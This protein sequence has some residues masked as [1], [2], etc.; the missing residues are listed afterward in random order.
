[1]NILNFKS[2]EIADKNILEP[3]FI[4]YGA[5]SCQ[6]SF[7]SSICR[8]AKYNDDYC[9]Y[10]DY[11][12]VLR[13]GISDENEFKFLFPLG[14][15]DDV[16][17][18][19]DTIAKIVDYCDDNAV[20]CSFVSLTKEQF[21]VFS[22]IYTGQY[23]YENNR[24]YYE[25]VYLA[26]DIR[27]LSGQKYA[28]RRNE[29]N[30]FNV[31]YAKKVEITRIDYSDFSDIRS[32]QNEWFTSKVKGNDNSY[33][34][35]L[36]AE[37]IQNALKYYDELNL[38]GIII[39]IDRKLVGYAIGSV[40]SNSTFD[41]IFAKGDSRIKHIYSKLFCEHIRLC[42]EDCR[43]V[44]WEEDLGV[45]GLRTVKESYRPVKLIEKYTVKIG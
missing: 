1:M 39:R 3:Y 42:G 35:I 26:E 10:N 25:Y 31:Q 18:L 36:E 23:S 6:Y 28:S 15:L 27:N 11:L 13:K 44:N 22:N 17:K 8:K 9:I 37:E 19:N 41:G 29:I 24:D 30:S 32:F 34:L 38:E 40:I 43:Y 33:E 5:G 20:K 4:K 2:I 12:I 21:E 14:K 7:A 45:E 16:D